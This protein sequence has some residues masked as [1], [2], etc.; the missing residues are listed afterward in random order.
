MSEGEEKDVTL[1][2]ADDRRTGET[3]VFSS[4]TRTSV[5]IETF[6]AGQ[7]TTSEEETRL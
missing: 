7:R 1:E 3:Q 4:E 2:T 6:A 5:F